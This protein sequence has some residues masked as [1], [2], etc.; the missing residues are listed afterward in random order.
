MNNRDD[1]QPNSVRGH[2]G[3]GSVDVAA[4]NLTDE[5]R[6]VIEEHP[7]A[8]VLVTAGPGTGKTY[9]LV[10][11][12]AALVERHD[13]AA[14]SEVLLLT[15]SRAAVGELRHR[16]RSLGGDARF[17]RA[18]TFDS[19]A[20]RLLSQ[21]KP[22]GSWVSRGYDGRIED[23][24]RLLISDQRARR[25]AAEYRHVFVDE[26]QDVVGLRDE[27]LREILR[28][29]TGGWTLLGDPAQ[30]IYDFQLDRKAK[31]T[32]DASALYRW[33][34]TEF[35]DSVDHYRLTLNFRVRDPRAGSALWAGEAL[36]DSDPDF[37]RVRDRLRETLWGLRA[38]PPVRKL[39]ALD[40]TCA[41][42]CHTNGQALLISRRL[43][44]DGVPHRLQRS[45]TDRALPAW[46]AALFYDM[47]HDTIGRTAFE[48]I[49]EPILADASHG[50]SVMEA[51]RLLKRM[52]R[53]GGE[54]LSVSR[55]LSRIRDGHVPDELTGSPP[56]PLT[57][58]TIHRAKGLEFDRV[59]VLEP[60]AG[61]GEASREDAG[62]QARLDYVAMTRPRFDLLRW[63]ESPDMRNMQVR[64]LPSRRWVRWR[65]VRRNR[66]L[67][68]IEVQARDTSEH[69]PM[70]DGLLANAPVIQEYLGTN[71]GEGDEV[72]LQLRP[73]RTGDPFY[74]VQ[75]DG[76]A[77]AETSAEFAA[78]LKA[79]IGFTPK[80]GWPTAIAE[81][82]VDGIETVV[83]TPTAAERAGLGGPGTW[84]R[85]RLVGIGELVFD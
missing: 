12:I 22:G 53:G 5:Q 82:R 28:C 51:W 44:S 1:E 49:A 6:A 48:Q 74:E 60:K 79:A 85:P 70:R 33:I 66:L 18:V 81:L 37:Q 63:P 13:I 75:H 9:V 47:E 68:A 41:V 69:S 57:V 30:G 32:S 65:W 26:V 55:V 72:R 62:E 39:S 46:L 17:V 71:V 77:I 64:E 52:S 23:A 25:E 10:H 34:R 2:S 80:K 35:G 67:A 73:T 78:D 50:P 56:I 4:D 19:F 20:T 36:N 27:F 45:A 58:S 21:F 24:T 84:L 76:R 61:Y 43:W 83:G 54:S 38:G 29:T 11:R 7:S 42:L 59:L 3:G 31:K 40:G 8:R 16:V 14:G 15:F